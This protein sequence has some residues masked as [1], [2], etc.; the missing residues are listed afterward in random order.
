MQGLPSGFNRPQDNRGAPLGRGGW[1]DAGLG[2]P[3]V[4]CPADSNPAIP[5]APAREVWILALSL[6]DIAIHCRYGVVWRGRGRDLG[7]FVNGDGGGFGEGVLER[8][9]EVD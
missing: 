2:H 9:L 4:A 3:G 5:A 8:G 6:K 1:R 7:R